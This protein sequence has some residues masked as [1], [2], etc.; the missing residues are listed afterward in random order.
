[1]SKKALSFLMVLMAGMLFSNC[2]E[3]YKIQKSN[4]YNLK[5][6]KAKAYYEYE[7]YYHAKALLDEVVSVFRGSD[8]AEEAQMLY[9]NC[10]YKMHDYTMGSYY[11]DAFCK[12]YPYSKRY[13]EALFM[14][15]Q[16]YYKDSPRVD[17]DQNCSQKA[18]D[19]MQT[20]LNKYPQGEYMHEA[21]VVIDEMRQKLE[22]KSYRTAKLYFKLGEYQSATITLKNSLKDYPDTKYREELMYMVVKANFLLAENSVENKKAERY[23]STVTEYYSFID[24][25]PESQYISEI[26]TMYKQSVDKIKN[27]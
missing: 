20:Y 17:L 14:I 21:N 13:E 11:F 22:E 12:T 8:K 24:E 5:Y 3:Y 9:A 19:A 27:L 4:D 23:Q 18:I 7:D 10:H 1:M 16:C 6:E 25:F 15:G 2:S 26:E